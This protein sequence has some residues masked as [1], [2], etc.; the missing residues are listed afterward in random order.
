MLIRKRTDIKLGYSCNNNCRFCGEGENRCLGDRPTDEIKRELEL[1]GNYAQEVVLTGGEPTLRKDIFELIYYA[2]KLGFSLIQL[3]TNGRMFSYEDFTKKMSEID[4]LQYFIS[5]HGHNSQLHDSLTRVSGSFSQTTQ[6]IK[7]LKKYGSFIITDT[8][9]TKQNYKFLPEIA[10]FL[11]SL[12]VN[13]LQ[14]CF[15]HP[16]GNALKEFENVVPNLS[17]VTPYVRKTLDIGK[18]KGAKMKVE[19]I[20]FCLMHNYEKNIL[21]LYLRPRDLMEL[22]CT[23]HKFLEIQKRAKG[24]NCV[25]CKY[26]TVCLG[27]WGGYLDKKGFDEL[28]PVFGNQVDKIGDI[29]GKEKAVIIIE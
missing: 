14:F 24:P 9:I 8:V 15:I 11:I 4:K 2:K 22:D 20:P 10:K 23:D 1:R 28:R 7:N 21:E 17:T 13:Q 25:K 3:Q 26:N 5:I 18:E 27:T 12:K 16:Q 19:G 6:G 29:I